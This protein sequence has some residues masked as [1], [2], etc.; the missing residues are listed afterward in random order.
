MTRFDFHDLVKLHSR[1]LF[2]SAFRILRNQ[3]E[4]EDAVQEVF[5][6]L[7]KMGSKIEEYNSIEA[8]AVTMTKNYCLDELK[9]HKYVD[10]DVQTYYNLADGTEP[11]PHE[12]LERKETSD[13]ISVI[14]EELPDNYRNMIQ[15]KEIDGFTYEE[16]A[17]KT[18]QNINTIRATLSR[19]RKVVRDKYLN[20]R[21]EYRRTE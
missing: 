13:I 5:I 12:R 21:D 4:A 18:N 20:Y 15:L 11:S 1:K 19:A 6:K 17:E 7:W 2:G 8:L 10:S 16:I 14:I 3:E 9:K